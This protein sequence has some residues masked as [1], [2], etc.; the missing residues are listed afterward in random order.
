MCA[1]AVM[2]LGAPSLERSRRNLSPKALWLR[3]R[4][5][6][7]SR[8]AV[9]A[10]LITCRVLRLST[11][12]PLIRLSGHKPSQEVKSFSV[13]QRPM[14]TPT[15]EIMVCAFCTSML[16][17]R[18]RSTPVNSSFAVPVRKKERKGAKASA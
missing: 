2:A 14:S 13:F 7:A 16:S 18:V 11:L 9:E 17:I 12:P 10:R 15:S 3:S 8:K 6:A 4:A 5:E 1:I